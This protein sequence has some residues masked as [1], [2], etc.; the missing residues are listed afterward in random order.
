MIASFSLLKTVAISFSLLFA[1]AFKI[2]KRATTSSTR[3]IKNLG[4][5]SIA[6][7]GRAI[8][9]D[10]QMNKRSKETD[11]KSILRERENI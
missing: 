6:K 10:R 9:I 11:T 4:F 8:A 1:I 3:N 2:K 7:N 5:I